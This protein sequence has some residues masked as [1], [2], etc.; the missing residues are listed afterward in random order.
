MDNDSDEP[1]QRHG[2]PRRVEAGVSSTGVVL[3]RRDS[4]VPA[5]L[6]GLG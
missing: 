3:R 1:P 2:Y 6:L 5:D 4:S